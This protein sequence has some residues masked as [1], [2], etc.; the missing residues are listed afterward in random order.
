MGLGMK[1][2][3]L[4][5]VKAKCVSSQNLDADIFEVESAEYVASAIRRVASSIC[6]CSISELIRAVCNSTVPLLTGP[7]DSFEQLTRQVIESLIGNGDLIEEGEAATS[8]DARGRGRVLY[9]R[10]PSFVRRINGSVLLIGIPSGNAS[11]FQPEMDERIYHYSHVRRMDPKVGEDLPGVLR[12]IGLSELSVESW[13]RRILVPETERPANYI[14]TLRSLLR[15][16]P[17]ALDGLEVLTSD[18]NIRYYTHRWAPLAR[19]S[20]YFVARRPQL[21]GNNLW[22]YVEIQN[23][24]PMRMIDLPAHNKHSLGRDEAWRLQMAI[25]ADRGHPQEFTIVRLGDGRVRVK[26]FS[27]IPSWAQRRW[28]NLGEPA[29]DEDCLISYNFVA[30]DLAPEIQ[31]ITDKLWLV[32]GS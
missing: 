17:G 25:D 5:E 3:D 19:Q 9:L 32:E 1:Q 26:F 10:P 28:D 27:P 20:G 23:G 6:P 14:N 13:E 30:A 7:V 18:S 22:C 31:F 2:L 8:F 16:N 21:F 12:S 15:S 29:T 4:K 24:T 11:I